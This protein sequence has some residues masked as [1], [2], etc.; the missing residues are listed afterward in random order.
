MKKIKCPI[1]GSENKESIKYCRI[2]FSRLAPYS[3]SIFLKTNFYSKVVRHKNILNIILIFLL[4]F[5][6][7]ILTR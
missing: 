6:I 5:I 3:S 7:W 2:C 4:F 1:C